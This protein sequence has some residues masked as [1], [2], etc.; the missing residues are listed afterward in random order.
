MEETKNPDPPLDAAVLEAGS[1][2]NLSAP[3][4]SD[5]ERQSQD[6]TAASISDW[7]WKQDEHNPYNWPKWKKNL[8]LVTIASIAFT[9]F[10]FPDPSLSHH[11][12]HPSYHAV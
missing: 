6:Q 12:C 8:Q 4:A 10:V 7:D 2:A 3:E 9:W 11:T 5:K 1:I